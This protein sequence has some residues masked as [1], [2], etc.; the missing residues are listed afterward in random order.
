MD[1]TTDFDDIKNSFKTLNSNPN[2]K[3]ISTVAILSVFVYE[4]NSIN[5]NVPKKIIC[6]PLLSSFLEIPK[7]GD[8]VS[9]L[10]VSDNIISNTQSFNSF[11]YFY[12]PFSAFSKKF[13]QIAGINSLKDKTSGKVITNKAKNIL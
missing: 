13:N 8:W 2:K 9:V 12:F 3:K 11:S 5:S 4:L 6:Y 7:K 10:G 1:E